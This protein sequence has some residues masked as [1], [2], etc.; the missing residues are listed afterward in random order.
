MWFWGSFSA[1][2]GWEGI[3]RWRYPGWSWHLHVW[4][5]GSQFGAREREGTCWI[6]PG[7]PHPSPWALMQRSCPCSSTEV[8]QRPKRFWMPL[9]PWCRSQWPLLNPTQPCKNTQNTGKGRV[10]LSQGL[11]VWIL[12][13][14]IP[15]NTPMVLTVRVLF[16]FG[17]E[18]AQ[19]SK[20]FWML[21][22]PWHHSQWSLLDP[23]QPCKAPRIPG[24]LPAR[25]ARP[26]EGPW[27]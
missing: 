24:A 3:V 14:H 1:G 27:V 25:S 5:W 13:Y 16:T 2:W 17:A 23:V 12:G 19:R 7:L 18:V 8:T 26:F 22:R 11:G 9:R 15:T 21:L 10:S 20:S 4:G 6:D